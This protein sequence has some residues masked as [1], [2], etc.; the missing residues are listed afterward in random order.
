[1]GTSLILYA[2]EQLDDPQDILMWDCGLPQNP[3]PP[4]NYSLTFSIEGLTNE[5][6]GDC[7]FIREGK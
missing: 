6:Y 2:M 3:E 4:W 1:M 7:L 5:Y